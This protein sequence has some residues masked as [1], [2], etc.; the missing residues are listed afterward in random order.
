MREISKIIVRL[1][2]KEIEETSLPMYSFF[3]RRFIRGNES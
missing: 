3:Q 1:K 2:E